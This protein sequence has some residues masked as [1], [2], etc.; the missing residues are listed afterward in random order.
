MSVL[1]PDT[2][3][4]KIGFHFNPLES[5][6]SRGKWTHALGRQLSQAVT[7]EDESNWQHGLLLSSLGQIN[8]KNQ[9]KLLKKNVKIFS[10]PG[11]HLTSVQM[12]KYGFHYDLASGEQGLS[13][14][15]LSDHKNHRVLLAAGGDSYAPVHEMMHLLDD[16]GKYSGSS[17]WKKIS[18]KV[19]L[20]QGI[21]ER[22]Y[23]G[24]TEPHFLPS[25]VGNSAAKREQFAELASQHH[26]DPHSQLSL[27]DLPL[28][29]QLQGQIHSFMSENG[30]DPWTPSK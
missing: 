25:V 10:V 1:A 28:I 27:G 4:E 2:A 21:D 8:D 26:Q 13:I 23:P 11:D 12:Q 16:N 15:G 5:R 17:Q 6:D 19:S 22:S 14:N 18:D 7:M 24:S 29:S 9:D 20:Y 30:L 3:I